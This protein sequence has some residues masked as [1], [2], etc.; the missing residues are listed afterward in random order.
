M[1]AIQKLQEWYRSRCDGDWEHGFGVKITTLDNPGWSLTINLIDTPLEKKSFT[2]Y[3][4]EF[5][6]IDWISCRV[7]EKQFRAAGGPM[8]LEELIEVFLRWKDEKKA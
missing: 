2:P 8:K 4:Y 7:E 6:D 1:S 3:E 5:S